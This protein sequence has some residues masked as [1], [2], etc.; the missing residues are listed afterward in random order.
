[1]PKRRPPSRPRCGRSASRRCRFPLPR[2]RTVAFH[3]LFRYIVAGTCS[4]GRPRAGAA[5]PGSHHPFDGFASLASF[6]HCARLPNQRGQRR[7]LDTLGAQLA[8]SPPFPGLFQGHGTSRT[9][10][11]RQRPRCARCRSSRP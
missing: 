10:F 2:A 7:C 1:M 8:P 6:G 11:P 4:T 3:P 5:L 9:C